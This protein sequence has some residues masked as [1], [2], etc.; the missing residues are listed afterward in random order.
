MGVG[1]SLSLEKL[2]E[3]PEQ[4]SQI[5]KVDAGISPWFKWWT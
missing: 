2:F 3:F 1:N 5:K 4:L